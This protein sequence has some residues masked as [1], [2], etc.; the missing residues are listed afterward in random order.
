MTDETNE[1]DDVIAKATELRE[2]MSAA[3]KTIR[4]LIDEERLVVSVLP[5]HGD[6]TD[7]RAVLT[8]GFESPTVIGLTIDEN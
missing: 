5:P 1:F 8:A 4:D 6:A 2:T 3:L 7:L